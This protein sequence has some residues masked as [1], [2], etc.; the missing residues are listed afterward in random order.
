MLF[1]QK[2]VSKVIFMY[3]VAI[4]SYNTETVRSGVSNITKKNAKLLKF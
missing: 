2:K 3:P 1:T 4:A